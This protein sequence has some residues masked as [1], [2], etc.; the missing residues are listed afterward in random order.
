MKAL[1]KSLISR[2][3]I[4]EARISAEQRKPLPDDLRI[5]A[6]KKLKLKLKE[7][8]AF[9]ERSDEGLTAKLVRSPLLPPR[10]LWSR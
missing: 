8:I 5:R 7:Q 1:L 3:E 6:M 10:T 2:H 4:L 9:L